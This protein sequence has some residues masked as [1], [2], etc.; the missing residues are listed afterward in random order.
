MMRALRVFGGGKEKARAAM[1]GQG[2][3]EHNAHQ[4]G[5]TPRTHITRTDNTELANSY[6]AQNTR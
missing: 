5:G 6:A 3:E 1:N 2:R 4:H